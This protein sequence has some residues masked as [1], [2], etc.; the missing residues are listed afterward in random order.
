MKR[1]DLGLLIDSMPGS[2]QHKW[3]PKK[4]AGELKR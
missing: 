3:R 2:G 4:I 1:C